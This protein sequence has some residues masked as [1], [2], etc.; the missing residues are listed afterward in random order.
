MDYIITLR[1]NFFL[2]SYIYFT[3]LVKRLKWDNRCERAQ[4][5]TVSLLLLFVFSSLSGRV[6]SPV[7]AGR[8]ERARERR[9]GYECKLNSKDTESLVCKELQSRSF[10][11][12]PALKQTWPLSQWGGSCLLGSSTGKDGGQVLEEG[13]KVLQSSLALFHCSY[14]PEGPDRAENILCFQHSSIYFGLRRGWERGEQSWALPGGNKS[15]QKVHSSSSGR[16][17]GNLLRQGCHRS[18]PVA[19]LLC[20][21]LA[22][23]CQPRSLRGLIIWI[24]SILFLRLCLPFT[25]V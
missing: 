5:G 16:R 2:V 17:G 20:E 7:L 13:F 11:S 24:R 15:L 21:P 23:L 12:M 3:E 4:P 6:V 19:A 25:W 9:V 22:A 8:E 1:L 18:R 14:F 10:R